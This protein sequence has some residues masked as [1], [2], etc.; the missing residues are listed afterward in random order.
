MTNTKPIPGAPA[1]ALSVATNKG[2]WTLADQRP[3]A[4]TL[5]AFYRGLHCPICK[6][7]L[8]ELQE[9]R[10]KFE[11][12]GVHVIALSMDDEERFRK[13][14]DDW[15]LND[16]EIGYGLSESAARE[17]GLYISDA[18]SDKEPATFSEPGLFLV[19]P[20]GTLY[21][22]SIQSVPFAR[23]PLGDVL[24]AIDFVTKND[25]PARG[26]RV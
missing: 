10:G 25:Y 1:P 18:I 15:D 17:W 8:Q 12:R 4:F 22:A 24:S 9:M 14:L 19:K 21:A 23:P 20:D 2:A 5:V 7:Q 16:L 6:N 13:T 11:A 3:D 26:A